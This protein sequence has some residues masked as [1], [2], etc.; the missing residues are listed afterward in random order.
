MLS[1]L[2]TLTSGN[3]EVNRRSRIMKQIP[4]LIIAGV[5]VAGCSNGYTVTLKQTGS[6]VVA[7][8]SGAIN[9][10]GLT[11][12]ARD[13][14]KPFIH[15][16]DALILTGPLSVS[17]FYT[18]LR[19]GA[20]GPTDFETNPAAPLVYADSASGDPVGVVGNGGGIGDGIIMVPQGYISG[21][22][23]SSSATWNNATLDS[24]MVTPGKTYVWTWGAGANQNFTLII[25]PIINRWWWWLN[26]SNWHFHFPEW[27]SWPPTWPPPRDL[28]RPNS[29]NRELAK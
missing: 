6:H 28:P 15:A 29:G 9:L 8:G 14:N 16:F 7:T 27:R 17:D 21:S 19:S 11:F 25:V 23:L 20:T 10:T 13:S 1:E 18:A 12:R 2:V 5:V 24:L 3:A 22:A 4:L 26:P